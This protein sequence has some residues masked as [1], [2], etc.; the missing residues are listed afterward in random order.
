MYTVLITFGDM[1]DSGHIYHVGDS[2]PREGYAPEKE[3]IEELT[4]RENAFGQPIIA[5][6]KTT[7]KKKGV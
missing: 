5:E 4:G 1:Q 7:K 3:R 2:Y 6:V